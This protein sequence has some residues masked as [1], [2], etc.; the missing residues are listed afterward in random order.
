MNHHILSNTGGV[1]H[2]RTISWAPGPAH[3][4]GAPSC[5]RGCQAGPE[6][7]PTHGP[8]HPPAKGTGTLVASH[9]AIRPRPRCTPG[10]PRP[11]GT[12]CRELLKGEVPEVGGG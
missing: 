10:P 1:G 7:G 9:G 12:G 4:R 2:P 11:L 6:Q 3:G 5:A 8:C